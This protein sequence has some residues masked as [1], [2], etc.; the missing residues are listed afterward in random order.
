M[1]GHVAPQTLRIK[2][3]TSVILPA[4]YQ[5]PRLLGELAFADNLSEG[6]LIIGLGAGSLPD[7][8]KI[9][10][11]LSYFQKIYCFFRR[12]IESRKIKDNR[13]FI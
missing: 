10:D 2:L 9:L 4:L 7:E 12:K 8:N 1:I 3:G 5:P 11:N 6:R 13:N